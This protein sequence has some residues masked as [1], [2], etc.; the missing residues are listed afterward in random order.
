M[1]VQWYPGHMTK[2]RRMMEENIRLVDLVIEL[3]D[4]RIPMSSRNPDIDALCSGKGRVVLLCKADLADPARTEAYLDFFRER[5]FLAVAA[6]ARE[7]KAGEVVRRYVQEACREKIA[8]D[9]ARGI[10][11]RPLRAMVA[12]IPNVGKS[13]FINSFAGRA[14]TKTGNKPGVTRGK[15]WIRLGG[16]VELLDTPGILWPKFDDQ[17]IGMRLALVGAIRDEVLDRQELALWLLRWLEAEYPGVVRDK[18]LTGRAQGEEEDTGE[19]ETSG[20]TG[21]D[22]PDAEAPDNGDAEDGPEDQVSVTEDLHPAAGAYSMP[23][24]YELLL[25]IA[26]ARRL[27]RKGGEPDAERAAAMLI[28]DCRNGRIGRISLERPQDAAA[29]LETAQKAPDAEKENRRPAGK[30][31]ASGKKT[32]T[33]PKAG[34]GA[35]GG[36]ASPDRGR[37]SAE[38]SGRGPA[39][40]SRKDAQNRRRESGGRTGKGTGRA[41]G[42]GSPDQGRQNKAGRGR[43]S[44]DRNTG[45]RKK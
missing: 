40:G 31:R 4:A 39:G 21:A 7:K 23:A 9:K 1:D 20:S 8:R 18:Y 25:E 14:S 22:V 28:D 43:A 10:V 12:G 11:G 16:G 41:S 3:V 35:A 29:M 32:G 42:K 2:A 36:K 45:R 44:S 5:G 24:E 33:G 13:T 17:A 38:R 6:D 19:Q 34:G 15:Q 30:S 26:A 37:Q 27:L